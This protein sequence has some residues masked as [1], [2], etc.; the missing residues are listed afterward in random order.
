MFQ[1][2]GSTTRLSRI[3]F[4]SWSGPQ[5]S[6]QIGKSQLL[7]K[8]DWFESDVPQ[9]SVTNPHLPTGITSHSNHQNCGGQ[10]SSIIQFQTH[11][12]S[13][14][15][16]YCWVLARLECCYPAAKVRIPHDGSHNREF[17]LAAAA[18]PISGIH[19][20]FLVSPKFY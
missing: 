7:S 15:W 19:G 20:E 11:I 13:D 6:T 8:M 2:G 9:D 10:L 16:A 12:I 3:S 1:R 17:L 14:L 18:W 4:P 5:F